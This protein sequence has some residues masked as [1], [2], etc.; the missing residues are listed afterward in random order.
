MGTLLTY[1]DSGYLPKRYLFRCI[2]IKCLAQGDTNLPSW[3][4]CLCEQLVFDTLTVT[5]S[6][7]FIK[8]MKKVTY[9]DFVY[10]MLLSLSG[11]HYGTIEGNHITFIPLSLPGWYVVTTLL[12]LISYL[13]LLF[14]IINDPLITTC[15][16]DD[17]TGVI[18]TYHYNKLTS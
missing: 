1:N 2:G 7:V 6:H 11:G 13:P 12:W 15:H 9:F 5:T 17:S 3:V 4:S 18:T 10:K 8:L 14:S 16:L